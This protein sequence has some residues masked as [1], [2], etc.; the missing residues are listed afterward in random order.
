[1]AYN[2]FMSASDDGD[3]SDSSTSQKNPFLYATKAADSYRKKKKEQDEEKA[4]IAVQIKSENDKKAQTKKQNEKKGNV[5]TDSAKNV[6]TFIKDAAVDVK[7]TTVGAVTGIGTMFDSVAA[8]A[9]MKRN[10]E[11]KQKNTQEW[12]R[13]QN[14]ILGDADNADANPDV[15]AKWDAPE[16]Q[17][18]LKEFSYKNMLLEG[19]TV[20]PEDIPQSAKKAQ[21]AEIK[22][23]KD[24]TILNPHGFVP[25]EMT[26]PKTG[27]ITFNNVPIN[28]YK[29]YN[30]HKLTKDDQNT[31]DKMQGLDNKKLAAQTAETF[32]NVATLG[33]GTGLK[34]GAKQGV[35]TAIKQ[36]IKQGSKEA[37][38]AT[39]KAAFGVGGKQLAATAVKDGV[40]GGAF[41]ITN[42]LRNDPNDEAGLGD[43]ARNILLG[44][45]IGAALPVVGKTVKHVATKSDAAAGNV[46]QKTGEKILDKKAAKAGEAAAVSTVKQEDAAMRRSLQT[47]GENGIVGTIDKA[48]ARTGRKVGYAVED[49]VGRTKAGA[50]VQSLQEDFASKWIT[51]FSPLY[52]DL[53]RSDFEGR[54][55]G[56]YEAARNAIG[57]SNR[58]LS[59]AQD[60][61]EY[62]PNMQQLT[63]SIAADGVDLVK[64]RARFDEY[65]AVKS[66]LD[67]VAAGKKTFS[68]AKMAD[69]EKRSAAFADKPMDDQYKNLVDFYSDLND[70]KL[71]NGLMS[72]DEHAMFKDEPFDYVRQQRE[73]PEWLQDKPNGSNGSTASITSSGLKQKRNQYAS[74][75]ILS[76]MET[77]IKTA[78]LAHT[79][80]YRNKA[81][82]TI[83]SLLD[84]AGEAKIV[85]TTEIVK[86][87]RD[88]L[89]DMK[90]SKPIVG[91]MQKTVRSK[92]KALNRLANELDNMNREGMNIRLKDKTDKTMPN[93]TPA[94]LGGDVSTSKAGQVV[95]TA[96]DDQT[97]LVKE[98]MASMKRTG[99]SEDRA[100]AKSLTPG[101]RAAREKQLAKDQ[102]VLKGNREDVIA[103]QAGTAAET[104]P[105]M[106][107]RK[108]TNSFLQ[109]LVTADPAQLKA[110]R[111]KM[112][113]RT[114]KHSDLFDTV[115]VLNQNLH[116][117]Q[118]KRSGQWNE[119]RGLKVTPDK[120]HN[121]TLSFL[122]DG[123]ENVVNIDPRVAGAIHNWDKQSQNIMSDVLRRTNNVFK[124]GTTGL[125]VGFA[126][127]NFVAD[128]FNAAANSKNFAAQISPIN[129]V[130]SVFMTI[131]KP[132][133]AKDAEWLRNYKAGNK[134]QISVNQYTKEKT[135]SNAANDLVKQGAPIT[136]KTATYIAHPSQAAHA[137]FEGLETAIGA[138]ENV[139]RIQSYRAGAKTAAKRGADTIDQQRIGTQAAR[140]NSVDFLE[141]GNYGRV[142][143]NLIPYFNASIQGSRTM[144]RNASERP[145][146]FA[147][148][149][150]ALVGVPIAATTI[151]NTSDPKRN[152]IYKTIP[153]YV[154]DGNFIVIRPDASWNAEKKKWDGVIIMKKPLGLKE[155]AE[156]VR[157]FIEYKA[158]NGDGATIEEFLGD[159]GGSIAGDF[160]QS[161]QPI[162]FSSPNGFLSS[163][164]PQILKPTAEAILN[165]NFFQGEDI[166]PESMQDKEAKDQHY[167]NFSR[168]TAAIGGQF[169]VSPLKVDH[170]IRATFGEAGT[171]VQNTADTLLG[172]PNNERGGR[173]LDESI[174]R[175]FVGASGGADT[176]AFYESYN[177][178]SSARKITSAKV[179]ELVKA[180]R[181]N[182]AKRRA[183][184]YN[185]SVGDRFDS[186]MKRYQDSPNYDMT[187][188]DKINDLPIKTSEQAFKARRK[189]PS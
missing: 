151:W 90:V 154:K 117:L 182:E 42:T 180:G 136:K 66:E 108:D 135:T 161:L 60:F 18:K 93:F 83:Y 150:T 175:R 176:D 80:A 99:A 89:T 94:G 47:I 103:A 51:S 54:T 24:G 165:K 53:K 101:E 3:S 59:Y 142:V 52:K 12:T 164:T 147:A 9:R 144:L 96:Q 95:E 91:K 187:W 186:F 72:A 122:D 14:S 41:G 22:A 102:A 157:K 189:Q 137:L 50:K 48:L 114:D 1:M 75:E 21:E 17:E 36:G 185:A 74:G 67:L 73:I 2:P 132:L 33:I 188:D 115:E 169:N 153:D 120:Q 15:R 119:A 58:S 109:S 78:Q 173:S 46:V 105:S 126:L 158:D 98:L 156:P 149:A 56:A 87:K 11:L 38:E 16:T 28:P 104:L 37:A 10:T 160:A 168:L 62:N 8:E 82:K 7:D 40:V 121:T 25:Q 77:A 92:T 118:A 170:W 163:V 76:P 133:N 162:D 140:E 44:A 30:D 172:A 110:L 32:L 6:G 23:H 112:E 123:I 86:Q 84:E 131:G 146:S 27:K 179:T 71:E 61:L 68:K 111:K 107:G 129:F 20:K 167:D 43:Y 35:K 64:S 31:F 81:A 34:Q 181:V 79:E 171:N 183:E 5:F 106:M 124:Y 145:A 29:Q 13:F 88:L 178:A 113:L 116:E 125:N 184:E 177:K 55:T 159:K 152:E 155:F 143:N 128:Q 127:P 138:T 4:S 19:K 26:D 70:F 97:D 139:T 134:G 85:R 69:L 39:A 130:H 63:A 45:S 57:N 65:A 141:M 174:T 166:V 49:A 100:A 148:K